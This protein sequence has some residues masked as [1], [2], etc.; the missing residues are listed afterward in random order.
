VALAIGSLGGGLRVRRAGWGGR[1][2]IEV[3][4]AHHREQGAE[5][6]VELGLGLGLDEREKVIQVVTPKRVDV[7]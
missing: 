6:L 3:P 2:L 4:E 1:G 7:F 5:H